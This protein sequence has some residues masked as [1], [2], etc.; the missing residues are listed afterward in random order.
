MIINM[1]T[2][3]CTSRNSNN[4]F[5]FFNS[6]NNGSSASMCYNNVGFFHFIAKL[7]EVFND[8]RMKIHFTFEDVLADYAE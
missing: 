1:L 6:S 4:L 3:F 5:T 7:I 2:I 8:E